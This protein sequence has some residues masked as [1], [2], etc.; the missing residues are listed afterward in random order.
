MYC[1]ERCLVNRQPDTVVALAV[2]CR[3]W[4]CP[5]C[6]PVRKAQLVAECHRGQPNTFLTLTLRRIPGRTPEQAA[7]AL[8]R[9]WRLL[10]LRVI[11]HRKLRRLPFAAVLEAHE[12][13][14]P[15]LHIL[16]R[17]IWLDQ[18]WLSEQMRAI[19]DSP[20][21]HIQRID[22]QARIAGYVAKYCG[23]AA[24]KFGNAKRYYFSRDYAIEAKREFKR[25]LELKGGFDIEPTTIDRWMK[26]WKIFGWNVERLSKTAARAT[27]PP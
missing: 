4:T 21:V 13:G 10:R 8:T 12:S 27:K 22:N 24:H 7:L 11:R 18:A 14:Y 25:M 2:R 1:G 23:K 16:L 9:A 17:S 6:A 5:D 20:V 26:D 3:A 15:H 19:A